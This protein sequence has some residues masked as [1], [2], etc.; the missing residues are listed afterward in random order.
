MKLCSWRSKG[1][2][3][4]VKAF[5]RCFVLGFMTAPTLFARQVQ[6]SGIQAIETLPTY[7]ALMLLNAQ[8]LHGR[9][10]LGGWR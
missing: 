9:I 1:S 3:L 7:G 5:N 8:S 2:N 6:L 4:A 10:L